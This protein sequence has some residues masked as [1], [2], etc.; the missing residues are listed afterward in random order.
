M[1]LPNLHIPFLPY[2]SPSSLLEQEQPITYHMPVP[3]L[4]LEADNV[5]WFHRSEMER[6]FAPGWTIPSVSPKLDVNDSDD[7]IRADD[8]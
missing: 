7:E 1:T 3:L 8:I 5:F 6:N 4:Y 2:I